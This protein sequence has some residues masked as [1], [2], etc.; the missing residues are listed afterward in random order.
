VLTVVP[1]AAEKAMSIPGFSAVITRSLRWQAADALGIASPRVSP[2]T[3]VLRRTWSHDG[4][5]INAASLYCGAAPGLR[6]R[7][8]AR[9]QKIVLYSINSSA[10]GAAGKHSSLCRRLSQAVKRH[11][12][13]NCKSNRRSLRVD[14]RLIR[15]RSRE[16]SRSCVS[17]DGR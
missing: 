12:A 17:T 5:L 11:P 2:L 13:R 7:C 4:G 14:L 16:H 1:S 9:A 6:P 3:P 10:G 15:L 8:K